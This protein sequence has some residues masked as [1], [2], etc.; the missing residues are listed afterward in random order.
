MPP[1]GHYLAHEVGQ[2]AGVSGQT[3]GQWARNGYI[4]PSQSA[5]SPH[6][7]SFQDVA[8]A[9][10]VHELLERGVPYGE[11]KATISALREVRGGDWPLTRAEQHL[12]TLPSGPPSGRRRARVLA[13][14]AGGL[15]DIGRRGWQRMADAEITEEDLDRVAGLLSRGGWVVRNLNIRHVEV[16]PNRLS[17]RP[18]IRARRVPAQK[19]ARLAKTRGGL[20]SLVEDYELTADEI[21]DAERWWE[22]TSRFEVDGAA[23]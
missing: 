15:Y 16:N 20:L 5:G 6:V 8:E 3:I 13:E 19:V 4:R 10:L 7:Y 1:R 11:I 18:A 12:A 22:A 23:A 14:E 17:G 9:V 2:L 21:R